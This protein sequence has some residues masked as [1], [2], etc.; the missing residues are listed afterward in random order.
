[1]I[2][3]V[4]CDLT[5]II[6][7][8]ET[9][10]DF[11]QFVKTLIG[12]SGRNYV[13]AD[14]PDIIQSLQDDR[15][16][17]FTRPPLMVEHADDAQ[18]K[19]FFKKYGIDEIPHLE[20][21]RDLNNEM[22]KDQNDPFNTY[23]KHREIEQEIND[24]KQFDPWETPAVE[25]EE[26]VRR[27]QYEAYKAAQDGNLT[28]E[29]FTIDE[30]DESVLSTD[31]NGNISY[32]KALT[33]TRTGNTIDADTRDIDFT[34]VTAMW[35]METVPQRSF[36]FFECAGI[37]SSM[38]DDILLHAGFP[39]ISRPI[40]RAKTV[41]GHGT[42]PDA[43]MWMVI[44]C[45]S[46][47]ASEVSNEM[48][49]RDVP[50]IY[51][52]LSD[53]NFEI[54]G[55]V[56]LNGGVDQALAEQFNDHTNYLPIVMSQSDDQTMNPSAVMA[57]TIDD[58][59]TID[60]NTVIKKFF[61]V[62]IPDGNL[63]EIDALL[64]KRGMASPMAYKKQ[65]SDGCWYAFSNKETATALAN[66]LILDAIA[67]TVVL[68]NR[69]GETLVDTGTNLVVD[70]TTINNNKETALLRP[71]SDRS[72]D[73]YALSTDEQDAE[74]AKM[75]PNEFVF[76]ISPGRRKNEL[77][78]YFCP[79]DHFRDNAEL[80]D[81]DAGIEPLLKSV[82]PNAKAIDDAAN[83]FTIYGKQDKIE[84]DL[85]TAGFIYNMLFQI[86]LNSM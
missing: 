20:I 51:C 82:I 13:S 49:G 18:Q 64:T 68:V 1:M 66:G 41:I 38:I 84:R 85:I 59:Y 69:F 61:R 21:L 48:L 11:E 57:H 56:E 14:F 5:T 23:Q 27:A 55:D 71:W 32:T 19:K 30:D 12:K 36:W 52:M 15:V 16:K 29:N 7:A 73:F 8:C 37:G 72:A 50:H 17:N 74:L 40:M 83:C 39:N 86:H 26:D 70:T 28:I 60:K 81:Q 31:S 10:L 76:G 34:D 4:K 80:Y 75:R 2:Y 42:N 78:V 25:T 46:D 35:P 44:R 9:I 43:G 65:R 58:D 62:E 6:G 79:V 67:T 24:L 22:L 63:A 77:N 45:N 47:Q 33:H 3:A 53:Q 54:T